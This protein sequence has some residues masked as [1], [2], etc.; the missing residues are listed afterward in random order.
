MFK[1]LFKRWFGN[2]E[3]KSNNQKRNKIKKFESIEEARHFIQNLP[4]RKT[5]QQIV[6]YL[7]RNGYRTVRG[8]EFT[9]SR[10]RYYLADDFKLNFVRYRNAERERSRRANR[11]GVTA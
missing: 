4:K 8:C 3:T 5:K 11:K 6:R 2:T 10:L 9:E 7:N 1:E